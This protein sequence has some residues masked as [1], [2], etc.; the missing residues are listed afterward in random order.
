MTD[1]ELYCH[2]NVLIQWSVDYWERSQHRRNFH[3][4]KYLPGTLTPTL[5]HQAIKNSSLADELEGVSWRFL[6]LAAEKD[7]LPEQQ[8]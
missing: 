5:S 8:K 4:V 1:A 2:S 6:F 3:T 7:L